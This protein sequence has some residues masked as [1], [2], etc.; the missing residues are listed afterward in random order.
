MDLRS[1][2]RRATGS[3][4]LDPEDKQP[5][6]RPRHGAARLG[7][8]RDSCFYRASPRVALHPESAR[9]RLPCDGA[10]RLDGT[11][12]LQSS[13]CKSER[14]I[15]CSCIPAA[16]D[17]VR[18]MGQKT[19][20]SKHRHQTSNPCLSTDK[21]LLPNHSRSAAPWAAA[22][23]RRSRKRT[24]GRAL[25]PGCHSRDRVCRGCPGDQ[26]SGDKSGDRL[27]TSRH[28]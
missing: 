3:Q 9:S 2:R 12:L 8:A 18:S 1:G 22:R 17:L 13:R 10:G 14:P 4:R 28:K 24:S 21:S 20:T 6:Q 7:A 27:A 19:P 23:P 5:C 25:T 11:S 15:E 26:L 16:L